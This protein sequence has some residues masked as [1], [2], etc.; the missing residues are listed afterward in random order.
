MFYIVFKNQ[1]ATKH[2]S[3]ARRTQGM[4]DVSNTTDPKSLHRKLTNNPDYWYC[5]HVRG[6]LT[7]TVTVTLLQLASK[8]NDNVTM[9]ARIIALLQQNAMVLLLISSCVPLVISNSIIQLF[10]KLQIQILIY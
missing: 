1:N 9:C 4:A 3:I 7:V 6:V 8:H 5:S 2:F 10:I